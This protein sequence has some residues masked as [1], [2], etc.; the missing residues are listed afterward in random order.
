MIDADMRKESLVAHDEDWLICHSDLDSF[1]E[2]LDGHSERAKLL[3]TH[4]I[5]PFN[6]SDS[7]CDVSGQKLLLV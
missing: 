3:E 4:L 7:Y 6:R 2:L 1:S 5:E